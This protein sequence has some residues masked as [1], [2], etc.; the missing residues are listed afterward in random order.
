VF[1]LFIPFAS[2]QLLSLKLIFTLSVACFYLSES[3][4]ICLRGALPER[5]RVTSLKV[6][7]LARVVDLVLFEEVSP[8]SEFGV[9]SLIF[10]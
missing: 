8:Q 5:D 9:R 7:F 1:L 4:V 6:L 10:A 3:V 2:L